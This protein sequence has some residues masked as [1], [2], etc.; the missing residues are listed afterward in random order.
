MLF[1]PLLFTSFQCSQ[2]SN[3]PSKNLASLFL[4]GVYHYEHQLFPPIFSSGLQ[5]H[6]FEPVAPCWLLFTKVRYITGLLHHS[7]LMCR[8][9]SINLVISKIEYGYSTLVGLSSCRLEQ[10]Q[11]VINAA[12]KI[13]TRKENTTTLL[14]FFMISTGWVFPKE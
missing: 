11:R 8:S 3:L 1:I 12:A 5:T 2:L 10:L 13:I 7:H 6:Y 4:V 9:F 14:L